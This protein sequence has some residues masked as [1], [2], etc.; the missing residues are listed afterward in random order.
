MKFTT[1]ASIV[2]TAS[3]MGSFAHAGDAK[4]IY[5][6][7]CAKCHGADGDG[8]GRAGRSLKKKDLL[9]F[10]DKAV[11]AKFTDEELFKAIKD[12]GDGTKVSKEMEA[13]GSL[14]DDEIKALVTYIKDMAK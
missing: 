9:A 7:K 1:I 2:L 14:K 6:K 11:M 10:K 4:E 13:Y 5:E 8:Q 3:M 12:G